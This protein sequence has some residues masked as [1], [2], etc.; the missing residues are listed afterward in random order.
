M[1]DVVQYLLAALDLARA[2]HQTFEIGGADR[3]SYGELMR[4]YAGQRGLRRVMI[5][6]PAL[7]P[8]LSS[9]WLGL[10]TP[11]YARVGRQLIESIRHATVVQDASAL[12]LFSI[13]PLG[14]REASLWPCATRIRSWPRPAGLTSCGG[15]YAARLGWR[16]L[17]RSAG[18]V[19]DGACRCG[20]DRGLQPHPP[21][22]RDNWMVLWL[23]A[24]AGTGVA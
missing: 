11:L 10:V 8:R 18:G 9:W 1:S 13:W 4:Q 5:P 20:S 19:S 7:S 15:G 22:R 16:P 3:V 21:V 6:V 14:S 12:C 2:G 17:R 23:V 24:V